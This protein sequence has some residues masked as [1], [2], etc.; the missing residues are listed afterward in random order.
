MGETGY[1][2]RVRVCLC[3][4]QVSQVSGFARDLGFGRLMIIIWSRLNACSARFPLSHPFGI[5]NQRRVSA[6]DAD[7]CSTV[8]SPVS[9]SG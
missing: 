9:L 7:T 2:V 8:A 4:P 5:V 1:S 3:L 6:S